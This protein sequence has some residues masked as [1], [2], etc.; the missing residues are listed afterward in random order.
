MARITEDAGARVA[1]EL[2]N[3]RAGTHLMHVP[4][5]GVAPAMNA[6]LG[7]EAQVMFMPPTIAV[8]HI[9]SGKLRVLA[10]TAANRWPAM[11]D[12]P[13]VAETGVAG[14]QFDGAWH[15]IFAPAKTPDVLVARS[16]SE[17]HAAIQTPKV[18]EFLIAGG[19]EPIGDG[20]AA[21]RKFVV[22]ELKKWAELVQ[23]AKL[24]PE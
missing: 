12:V 14:Y 11:P 19:Y 6:L 3:L 9:K 24:K 22:P 1:G 20:P 15:G 13:T 5:K 4:Y 18:R 7:G 8:Q 23:I 10:C 17:V 2:F 21:F 16:Q